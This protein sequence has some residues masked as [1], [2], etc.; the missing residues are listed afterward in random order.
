M[1]T[2]DKKYEV[3]GVMD[4][5]IHDYCVRNHIGYVTDRKAQTIKFIGDPAK[6]Q[7]LHRQFFSDYSFQLK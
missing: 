3:V 4:N 2:T 1:K 6:L 5:E 7:D